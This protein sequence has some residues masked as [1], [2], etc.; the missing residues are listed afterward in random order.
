[1]QHRVV[2]NERKELPDLAGLAL[3]ALALRGQV[4]LIDLVDVV[5]IERARQLLVG[6]Y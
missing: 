2:N 1:M 5:G 6:L 3:R 4:E